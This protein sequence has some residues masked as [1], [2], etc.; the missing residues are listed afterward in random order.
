LIKSYSARIVEFNT[1]EL[2]LS[3]LKDSGKLVAGGIFVSIVLD[4]SSWYNISNPLK[5]YSIRFVSFNGLVPRK[6]YFTF[7]GK[8]LDDGKF[9][10]PVLDKSS[11]CK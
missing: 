2:I 4:R 3:I 6:K 5:L 7:F 8:L 9:V 1:F 11:V 10:M